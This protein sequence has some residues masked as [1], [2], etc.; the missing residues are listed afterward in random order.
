MNHPSLV[1]SAGGPT[2]APPTGSPPLVVDDRQVG[3]R[4]FGDSTLLVIRGSEALYRLDRNGSLLWDFLDSD[5]ANGGTSIVDRFPQ[6][7]LSRRETDDL[8]HDLLGIGALRLQSSPRSQGK[9]PVPVSQSLRSHCLR[10]VRSTWEL[11]E[12]VGAADNSLAVRV[13]EGFVVRSPDGTLSL[14][15]AEAAGVWRELAESGATYVQLLDRVI[16]R[17]RVGTRMAERVVSEVLHRLVELG[18]VRGL[19][20]VPEYRVKNR[21]PEDREVEATAIN[22]P[23]L[24]IRVGVQ[25]LGALEPMSHGAEAAPFETLGLSPVIRDID[26]PVEHVAIVCQY[27]IHGIAPGVEPYTQ[28]CIAVLRDLGPDLIVVSG[29][30]R[31]G[32]SAAREA[33]SVVEWYQAQLPQFPLWLEK[34]STT[35]WENIQYSLAMLAARSLKPVR[36]SVLC[37]RARSDKLR[38]ACW[39]GQRQSTRLREVDLRVI[40]LDRIRSTWRDYRWVQLSLGCP[41]IV[42][43]M[44]FDRSFMKSLS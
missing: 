38:L 25:R 3:W 8:L 34:H 11:V 42:R 19:E 27:G 12:E 35:S 4:R 41:Q 31:H 37:D 30:G 20:H 14:L 36:V 6:D 18:A 13:G 16:E 7:R 21:V 5:L 22:R 40:P 43:E 26:R 33:D 44:R 2:T 1:G 15:T 10:R 28:R 17:L 32:F 24:P 29:G 23:D 9:L 39:L